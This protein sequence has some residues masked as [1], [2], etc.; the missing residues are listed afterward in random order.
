MQADV[1]KAREESCKKAKDAYAKAIA[2]RRIYTKEG[3]NGERDYMSDAEADAFR[4]RM[5]NARKQ[6]CGS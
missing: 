6:A 2:S 4:L 3:P 1:A 5:M